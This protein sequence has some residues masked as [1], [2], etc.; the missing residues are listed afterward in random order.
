VIH[1][2]N[3]MDRNY[4]KNLLEFA[5]EQPDDVRIAVIAETLRAIL[6][7][8]QEG[9]SFR[10]FMYDRLNLPPSAYV[11]LYLAGGMTVT[12]AFVLPG[13]LGELNV[14]S[15]ISH[16]R[17][18]AEAAP[19]MPHQTLKR[20]TGEPIE[21]PSPERSALF[22]ALHAAV[23]L[24]ESNAQLQE[25]NRRLS[26]RCEKLEAA[27]SAFIPERIDNSFGGNH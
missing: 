7:N 5:Q 16:L 15:P 17:E 20:P 14:P 4:L 10:Y 23:D 21:F 25:A 13:D 1:D 26:E 8:A 9:G 22:A 6:D 3:A 11:P 12:N 24:A 2:E 27:R 19:M 18:M